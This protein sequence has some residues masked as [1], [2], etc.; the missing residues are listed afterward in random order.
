MSNSKHSRHWALFLAG[1][2][3]F[4]WV[5]VLPAVGQRVVYVDGMAAG[6]NDGASW[7]NAYV[8]LQD[9]LADAAASGASIHE[10]RVA[11][12]T[13]TPDQGIGYTP[14]DRTASFELFSGLALLGGYA[15]CASADPNA[16]DRE[17]FETILSGDLDGNDDPTIR[18]ES[19]CCGHSWKPGC[20]DA[21]CE[22]KVCTRWAMCCEDWWGNTCVNTAERYCCDLCRPTRCENSYTVLKAVDTDAATRIDGFTITGGESNAWLDPKAPKVDASLATGGG[23][24]V[25]NS[26]LIVSNCTFVENAAGGASAMDTHGGEPVVTNCIFRDNGWYAQGAGLALST[27][28]ENATVTDCQF[29]R[30]RGGGMYASGNSPIT[31]CTFIGNTRN[32]LYVGSGHPSISDCIFI[33]NTGGRGGG[34]FN[35]GFPQLINCGFYGNS[36]G[37]SGGGIYD[38]GWGLIL[39]NCVFSGNKAGGSIDYPGA[40]P[41]SGAGG[42]IYKG[43][44]PLLVLNCTI[45]GNEAEIVGGLLGLEGATIAHSIFWGNKSDD[46]MGQ[47]AQ[48]GGGF[49]NNPPQI[50]YNCI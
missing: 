11:R 16:R 10:I 29:I 38:G 45:V 41:R 8:N 14:G 46:G 30:N 50:R 32:G 21:L 31:R 25:R 13:Y 42:A 17:R 5:F 15:G 33:G 20:E 26:S 36:A 19:G 18:G 28:M 34:M 43:M 47:G 27:A 12:G 23:L 44:G 24:Y 9:A 3:V 39:I 1:V 48:L 6:V 2:Q 40:T 49:P 37:L 35:F 4:G 7:E 22:E